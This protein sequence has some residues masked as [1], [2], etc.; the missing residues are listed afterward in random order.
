M[1]VAI[2]LR[3]PG[4]ELRF[5]RPDKEL[6]AYFSENQ[7]DKIEAMFENDHQRD[8]V[9]TLREIMRNIVKNNGTFIQSEVQRREYRT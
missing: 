1:F 6:R 9:I 8:P 2:A 3:D 7:F 4:V 5:G